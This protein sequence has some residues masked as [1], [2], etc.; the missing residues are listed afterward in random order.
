MYFPNVLIEASNGHQLTPVWNEFGTGITTG[1]RDNCDH[2]EVND[3]LV[4]Y[5]DL[6]Q[7]DFFNIILDGVIGDNGIPVW[8]QNPQIVQVVY[9]WDFHPPK[10]YIAIALDR[11]YI[12]GYFYEANDF[13]WYLVQAI[14][15]QIVAL[16]ASQPGAIPPIYFINNSVHTFVGEGLLGGS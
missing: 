4:D 11:P 15:N 13:S 5:F 10:H 16:L 8:L 9:P 6:V 12:P 3:F 2:D 14:R 1:Y 7:I